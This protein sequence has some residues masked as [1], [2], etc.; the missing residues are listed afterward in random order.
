M[1]QQLIEHHLGA[2]NIEISYNVGNLNQTTPLFM[3][4]THLPDFIENP[5]ERG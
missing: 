3:P 5:N 2:A 1:R 4:S